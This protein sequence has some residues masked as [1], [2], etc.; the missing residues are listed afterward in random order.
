MAKTLGAIQIGVLER[1]LLSF[2]SISYRG[3]TAVAN[4]WNRNPYIV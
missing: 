2:D 4:T 3:V 1:G